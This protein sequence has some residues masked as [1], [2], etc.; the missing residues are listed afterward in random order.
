MSGGS[1]DKNGNNNQW[2]SALTRVNYK[3]K[4]KCFVD[5]YGR[6]VAGPY[7]L[8]GG[9]KKTVR[10]IRSIRARMPITRPQ[11]YNKQT[12]IDG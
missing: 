8:P 5:Y 11:A 12:S 9:V 1:Y 6:Q 7:L 10:I 2:W 4:S 3:E